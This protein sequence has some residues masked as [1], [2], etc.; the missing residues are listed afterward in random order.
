MRNA[1]KV[2]RYGDKKDL[3][4]VELWKRVD[5]VYDGFFAKQS[6]DIRKTFN[7]VN[8]LIEYFG[9]DS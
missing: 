3:K 4:Q 1:H 9:Y 8:D 2:K 5:T 6:Y 7:Q